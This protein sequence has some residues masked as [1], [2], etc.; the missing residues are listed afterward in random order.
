MYLCIRK[1]AIRIGV[2]VYSFE[3]MPPPKC[4]KSYSRRRIFNQPP[5]PKILLGA[6]LCKNTLSATKDPTVALLEAL[7]IKTKE[8]TKSVSTQQQQPAASN[9]SATATTFC[10][11]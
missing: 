3:D 4:L 8:E 11:Y 2:T 7:S 10:S 5:S 1:K 6:M 9:S